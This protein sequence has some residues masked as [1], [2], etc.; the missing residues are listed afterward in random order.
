MESILKVSVKGY[1]RVD[2]ENPVGLRLLRVQVTFKRRPG[3]CVRE[4]GVGEAGTDISAPGKGN[5]CCEGGRRWHF[6]GELK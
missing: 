4:A 6:G 3:G 2:S 5:T 1:G